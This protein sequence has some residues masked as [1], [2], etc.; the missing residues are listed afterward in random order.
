M[1]KVNAPTVW[2]PSKGVRP[3]DFA[4]TNCLG[5]ASGCWTIQTSSPD[6]A[7]LLRFEPAALSLPRLLASLENCEIK[8]LRVDQFA[9]YPETLLTLSLSY[10]VSIRMSLRITSSQYPSSGNALTGLAAVP[11]PKVPG[12]PQWQFTTP[13][14]AG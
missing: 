9:R 10:D 8:I 7:A 3:N 11:S 4:I 14:V 13:D 6:A 12:E 5:I 2:L 1:G